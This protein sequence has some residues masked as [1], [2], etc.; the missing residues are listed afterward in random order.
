MEI[1]IRKFDK[2]NKKNQIL[3]GFTLLTVD[4]VILDRNIGKIE[5]KNVRYV[6]SKSHICL[7]FNTKNLL[8]FFLGFFLLFNIFVLDT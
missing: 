3:T 2:T 7:R 5:T 1:L 4:F 6:S 8:T